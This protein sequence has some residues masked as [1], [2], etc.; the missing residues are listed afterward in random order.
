MNLG[1]LGLSYRKISKNLNELKVYN[2]M[3]NPWNNVAVMR[4]TNGKNISE[5]HCAMEVKNQNRI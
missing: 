2:R 1:I 3:K 4:V 5:T